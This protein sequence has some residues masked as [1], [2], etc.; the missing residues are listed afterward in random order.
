MKNKINSEE[1]KSLQKDFNENIVP[2]C[3]LNKFSLH[4]AFENC[5]NDD[6]EISKHRYF[7][8]SKLWSSPHGK[9]YLQNY[10]QSQGGR[11][12]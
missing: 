11:L 6:S 2:W 3:K 5:R 12:R 8:L 10:F 4:N 1:L 9:L 7:V